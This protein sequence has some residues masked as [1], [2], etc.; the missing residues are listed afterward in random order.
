M[1]FCQIIFLV[2]LMIDIISCDHCSWTQ[3]LGKVSKVADCK[4]L[5][6]DDNEKHCCYLEGKKDDKDVKGC[7]PLTEDDYKDMKKT[8][9]EIEKQNN[10]DVDKLDC[11]SFYLQIGIIS[12][13]FLIL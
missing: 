9:K 5:S 13:I 11:K 6:L 10:A 1:K 3:T 7:F 8:I 2:L 4:D 12:L